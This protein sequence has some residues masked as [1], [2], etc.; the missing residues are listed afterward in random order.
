M[1]GSSN[2]AIKPHVTK[3]AQVDIVRKLVGGGDGVM[4]DVLR[5][6]DLF[7]HLIHLVVQR[8]PWQNGSNFRS[9]AMLRA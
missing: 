3:N 7:N 5:V 9:L 4:C 1:A 6:G 8:C 2:A